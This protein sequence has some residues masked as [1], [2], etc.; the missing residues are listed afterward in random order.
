MATRV[1]VLNGGSSSGKSGIARCLQA[2]LPEPW[3]SLSVDT[4]VD[5]LPARLRASEAGIAFAEGGGVAVGGA[6]DALEAAWRRGVAAMAHAGARVVVDDVFLSG[7]TSQ[8][9]WREALAGLDVLW[10]GVHCSA[11]VAAGRELA[12][13][14]RAPGM[15][16][17]QA[18]AVHRGVTYDVR[19]D[20][21][22]TEALPCARA[23]AAHVT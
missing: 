14:D 16:A 22:E 2:V 12:R 6:F 19:V 9:R 5:A 7:P 18:E 20:T 1:I 15:A 23:V 3:L 10:V 13:G 21:T 8:G 4:L 17:G 11:E